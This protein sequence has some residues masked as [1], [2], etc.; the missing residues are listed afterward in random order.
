VRADISRLQSDLQTNRETLAQISARIDTL[1]GRESTL[2]SAAGKPLQELTQAIEVLLKKALQT[3]NRLTTLE[4][5][6]P[7]SRVPEKPAK[8]PRQSSSETKGAS[9]QKGNDH[10][11]SPFTTQSSPLS[12]TASSPTAKLMHLG[13]TQEDVRRALGNPLRTETAGS[14]IFWHYSRVNNQKY[15]I[16]ET[17]TRQVS[18]WWGL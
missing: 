18:G 15:V 4:S 10:N 5:A 17:D 14:H 3:E 8:Q 13:M 11:G 2:D 16:F 1:E 7:P 12:L 6:G 9:V